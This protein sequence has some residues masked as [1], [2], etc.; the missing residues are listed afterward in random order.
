MER[1]FGKMSSMY[2]FV[3]FTNWWGNKIGKSDRNKSALLNPLPTEKR[4]GGGG[5]QPTRNQ[6][7]NVT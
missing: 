3:S 7:V 6:C 1:L 2:Y 5:M 4:R